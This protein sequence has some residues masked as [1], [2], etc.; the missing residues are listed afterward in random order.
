MARLER[1]AIDAALATL[2][3][4]TY[5]EGALTRT[6]K[7]ATFPDA[8][9]FLVR[10]AFEAEAADHHPDATVSYRD[11]TLRYVTHSE[12]GVTD[13]DVEGARTASR[14]L[15]GRGGGGQPT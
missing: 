2:D 12:G 4:W 10:L 15:A 1:S 3:G 11:L 14:L 7:F 13:R 9:T 8:L 6:V 5:E